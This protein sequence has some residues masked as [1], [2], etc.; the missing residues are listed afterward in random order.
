MKKSKRAKVSLIVLGLNF[1]TFWLGMYLKSDLN[2][3]GIG[4]MTING[5]LLVYILG[6]SYRPS[7]FKHEKHESTDSE[8]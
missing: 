8:E 7:G 2:N 1:V 5:P 6:E 4:L 3:L